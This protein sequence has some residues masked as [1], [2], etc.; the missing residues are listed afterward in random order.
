M[1]SNCSDCKATCS[2]HLTAIDEAIGK[3]SRCTTYTSTPVARVLLASSTRRPR[4]TRRPGRGVIKNDR[5]PHTPKRRTAVVA[6]S[7][8]LRGQDEDRAALPV[9]GGPRPTQGQNAWGW[10]WC[11]W[12]EG[13]A[14]RLLSARLVHGGKRR[15]AEGRARGSPTDEKDFG[16]RSLTRS[17]WSRATAG[18]RCWRHCVCEALDA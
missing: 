18:N 6:R 5:R 8:A 12:A 9:T 7:P 2:K 4:R 3:R 15:R 1:Q 13:R 11:W 10:P 17:T 14:E 16:L